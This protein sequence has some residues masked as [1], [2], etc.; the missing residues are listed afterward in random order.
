MR[1][2]LVE[3]SMEMV[4][5]RCQALRLPATI[6]GKREMPADESM[7]T[8]LAQPHLNIGCDCPV[9][10]HSCTSIAANEDICLFVR[11]K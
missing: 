5:G 2:A 1:L 8:H 4:G 3:I 6:A 9:A 11:E 10:T 7:Q